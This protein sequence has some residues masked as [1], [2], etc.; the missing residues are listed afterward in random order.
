[1]LGTLFIASVAAL[2]TVAETERFEGL[3]GQPNFR[4]LGGYQTTDGRTIRT[5]LVYRSGELPRT[6]DADLETLKRLGVRT[7]VNF[8]TDGE[9]EFRGPDR[10]P[11]GVREISLPITGDVGGIPDAANMLVEARKTGDFRN[12]PPEFNPLVHEELVSGLADDQYTALFEVLADEANYPIVFHCSHGIHRTGT[13]AALVLTAL[14][15]SWDVVREDYLRSNVTRADEVAPRIEDLKTLATAFEM[16]P[17]E[18]ARNSASIEAF[19]VLEPEYIDASR[20]KAA[21]RFGSLDAYISEGLNQSP[22]D[23]ERLR[24]FLL[25]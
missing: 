23:L 24:A 15:V 10:L 21:Q 16:S 5:G 8:L 17:E 9:T 6:T 7:V 13:A 12:F 22:A 25:E 18:R 14:G 1:M 4:D 3:E 19:Y 20:T 11:E 2:A